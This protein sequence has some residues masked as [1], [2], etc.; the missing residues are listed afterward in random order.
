MEILIIQLSLAI[1]CTNDSGIKATSKEREKA[2]V[3]IKLN[4]W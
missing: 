3:V 4:G 1:S 2:M